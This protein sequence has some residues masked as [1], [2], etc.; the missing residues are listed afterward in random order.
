MT[1]RFR[2]GSGIRAGLAALLTTAATAAFALGGPAATARPFEDD[3]R[4][5]PRSVLGGRVSLDRHALGAG[6]WSVVTDTPDRLTLRAGSVRVSAVVDAALDGDADGGPGRG[7]VV[8]A[9]GDTAGL[10]TATYLT[11]PAGVFVVFDNSATAPQS[12]PGRLVHPYPS[13]VDRCATLPWPGITLTGDGGA[14]VAL[15]TPSM[16]E[17]TYVITRGAG[18]VLVEAQA[19]AAECGGQSALD[20]ADALVLT[21]VPAGARID[22]DL[23]PLAGTPR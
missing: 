11:R 9:L 8:A 17:R 19:P 12:A 16:V 14:P 22:D 13:S 2:H 21:L 10:A 7:D 4:E 3:E 1:G 20:V 18:N 5:G 6:G 23:S 15:G